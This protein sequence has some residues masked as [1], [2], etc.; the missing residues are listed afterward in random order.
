MHTLVQL[1]NLELFN[2]LKTEFV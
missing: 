2:S 1:N